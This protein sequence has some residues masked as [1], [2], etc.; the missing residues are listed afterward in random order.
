MSWIMVNHIEVAPYYISNKQ[1]II[2]NLVVNETV[3][4]R[5]RTEKF[6]EKVY[7]DVEGI[8]KQ[9]VAIRDGGKD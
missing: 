9:L 8:I 2:W 6:R 4:D 3:D 1:E 7:A 5:M